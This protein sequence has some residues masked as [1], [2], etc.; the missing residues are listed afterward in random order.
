[1]SKSTEVV[2]L[3]VAKGYRVTSTGR[4]RGPRGRRKLKATD[5]GHLTFT[6]R[7]GAEV[8]PVLVHKLAAYQKFGEDALVEGVEVRHKNNVPGDNRQSNLLLGSKSDNV[9][10]QLE[11]VRL[12]RAAHAARKQR[13]LTDAQV[14][15]LRTDR[16]KGALYVELC[17]KYGIS[18]STVSYIVSGVT[19]NGPHA[20]KRRYGRSRLQAPI[21]LAAF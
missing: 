4:V 9:L 1:M 6:V 10:D 7:N 14:R 18:K 12:R 2:K 17:E 13:K 16:E 8:F 5:R 3:A 19:Y 11:S 15:R 21:S 20:N